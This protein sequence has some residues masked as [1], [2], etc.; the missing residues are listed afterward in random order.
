MKKTLFTNGCSWTAGGVLDLQYTDP[1]VLKKKL[2]PHHL[3]IAMGFNEHHNLAMGCGSNQRIV[4]TTINWLLEQD[5]E[6]L[7]NTTAVIQWTEWSRY[8]Y[9]VPETGIDSM[10]DDGTD[11]RW[12]KCKVGNCIDKTG[13]VQ[14]N[15]KRNDQRLE[16][17]TTV[18][19]YY[20]HLSQCETLASLFKRFGVK[21]YYW[22]FVTPM[23]MI[24]EPKKSFLLQSYNW[25]EPN[26][27]HMWRYERLGNDPHPSEAGHIQL[28]Q[29]IKNA[30]EKLKYYG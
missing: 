21:Y 23:F 20:Q 13:S 1:N 7:K 26:G 3:M 4:R 12:A 11:N 28:S 10:T 27:R 16:T 30:I 9:Y 2:W 18:E 14:Y 5:E 25:L 19:G 8:E 6:T 17:F 29:H 24:P 15:Q 22:N